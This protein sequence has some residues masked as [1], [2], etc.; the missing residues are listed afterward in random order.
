MSTGARTAA[1]PLAVAALAFGA[2]VGVGCGG[3]E[4]EVTLP[5]ISVEDTGTSPIE[6]TG[7]ATTPTEPQTGGT[8]SGDFDPSQEDSATNDKPP[9]PGSPEAAFEEA[10]KQNPVACG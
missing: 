5:T 2:L 4:D 8:G 3:D 9:E 10:C 6:T 7:T 1:L